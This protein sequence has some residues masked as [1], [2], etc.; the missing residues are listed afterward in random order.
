[1]ILGRQ[2]YFFSTSTESL[3]Q[4]KEGKAVSWLLFRCWRVGLPA[5]E[6]K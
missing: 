1:M 3:M 2:Q 4:H 5:E 6:K